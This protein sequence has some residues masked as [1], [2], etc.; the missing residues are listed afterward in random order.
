MRLPKHKLPKNKSTHGAHKSSV[1]TN[2]HKAYKHQNDSI[3]LS[4]VEMME[5]EESAEAAEKEEDHEE[6]EATD[7]Q[8][9][10]T[11]QARPKTKEERKQIRELRQ[12]TNAARNLYKRRNANCSGKN[13]P[14]AINRG[15]NI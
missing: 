9:I 3:S 1:K 15:R 12:K 2:K 4:E 6:M 13:G 7:N 10:G 14:R 11:N 5:V 8:S